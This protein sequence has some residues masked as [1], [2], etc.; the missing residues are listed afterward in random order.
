VR[1]RSNGEPEAVPEAVP[2]AALDATTQVV[3]PPAASDAA[4]VGDVRD[5]AEIERVIR[6]YLSGYRVD[7]PSGR[8]NLGRLG[9]SRNL[10][11]EVSSLTLLQLVA[12]VEQKFQIAVRPID[13]VPRNFASVSAIATFIAARRPSVP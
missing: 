13:F 10:W 4:Q 7:G 8:G 5:I 12:F 11:R 3:E 6:R 9:A 1:T 2:D